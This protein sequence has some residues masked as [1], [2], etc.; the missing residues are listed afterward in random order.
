[1]IWEDWQA[2]QPWTVRHARLWPWWAYNVRLYV[3]DPQPP[4]ADPEGDRLWREMN[5][6]RIDAVGYRDGAYTLFEARRNTGWSA[7]GQLQGYSTLWQ[8]NHPDLPLA[9]LYLVT[10]TIDDA[11]RATAVLHGITVWRVGEP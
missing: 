1:M 6:K 10:E 3:G 11:I 5:A 4:I 8:L 9:G 7:I 2:W